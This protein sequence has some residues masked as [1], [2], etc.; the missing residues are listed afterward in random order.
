VVAVGDSDD[1][2]QVLLFV[3]VL[4]NIERVERVHDEDESAADDP[5]A[6]LFLDSIFEEGLHLQ[7]VL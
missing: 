7:L 3:D 2:D 4:V 1:E 5:S 6:C